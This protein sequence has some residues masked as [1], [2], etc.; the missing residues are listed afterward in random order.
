MALAGDNG[1]LAGLDREWATL[2]SELPKLLGGAEE[3][4]HSILHGD[5]WSGNVYPGPDGG[6]IGVS[7]WPG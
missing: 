2:E 7:F 4:G 3:D 5:L 1:W 6:P